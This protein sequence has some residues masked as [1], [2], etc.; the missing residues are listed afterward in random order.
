[1]HT[2]ESLQRLVEPRLPD[3]AE[4]VVLEDVK[5]LAA[6]APEGVGQVLVGEAKQLEE[7][8]RACPFGPLEDAQL[9]SELVAV[10][11]RAGG[12]GLL[13]PWLVLDVME[14]RAIGSSFYEQGFGMYMHAERLEPKGLPA[15]NVVA[16]HVTHTHPRPAARS[17]SFDLPTFA[18]L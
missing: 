13:D 16:V 3:L 9:V 10:A 18:A 7:L 14:G 11:E 5:V 12:E 15:V 8:R 6:V 17:L 2:P 4:H 1:M